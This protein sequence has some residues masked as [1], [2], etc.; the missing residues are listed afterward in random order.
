MEKAS[1][2]GERVVVATT[3]KIAMNDPY[4]FSNMELSSKSGIQ[5]VF[6]YGDLLKTE[7]E[8][9]AYAIACGYRGG[10]DDIKFVAKGGRSRI[11]LINAIEEAAGVRPDI[12]NIGMRAAEGELPI[13]KEGEEL[14][15]VLLE[16]PE[17]TINGYKLYAAINS[18]QALLG[19]MA[20]LKDGLTLEGVVIPGVSYESVK[21]IFRYLPRVLPIDYG[22]EIETYR[23]AMEYVRTAA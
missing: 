20:Q 17:I 3:E 13:S 14:S 10:I 19:I 21:R 16:I 11:G 6:I 7:E 9:R 12:H 5:N 2:R 8:A 1:H 23:R 18:Y 22:R 4:T 15:G